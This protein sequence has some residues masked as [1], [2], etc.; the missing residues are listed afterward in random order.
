MI[1]GLKNPFCVHEDELLTEEGQLHPVVLPY[2]Y[3][4]VTTV[5][6]S[7]GSI[8]GDGGGDCPSSP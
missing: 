5:A 2:N 3:L 6:S 8:G 7:G 4:N 1:Q